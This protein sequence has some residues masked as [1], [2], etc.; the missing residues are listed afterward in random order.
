MESRFRIVITTID[1][2][3]VDRSFS[4]RSLSD[5]GVLSDSELLSRFSETPEELN[6]VELVLFAEAVLLLL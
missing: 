1:Q 2:G 6:L 5:V 4:V 3:I